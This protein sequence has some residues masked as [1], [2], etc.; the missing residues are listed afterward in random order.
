LK[1][2]AIKCKLLKVKGGFKKIDI[3]YRELNFAI[4]EKVIDYALQFN[5][6]AYQREIDS[7]RSELFIYKTRKW[8]KSKL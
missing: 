7:I 4:A 6:E 8:K 3:P 2:E 1:I 5:K